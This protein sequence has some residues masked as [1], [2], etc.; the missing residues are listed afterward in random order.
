MRHRIPPTV[1]AQIET[2]REQE[3]LLILQGRLR[4][5]QDDGGKI[6]VTID[7]GKGQT[8]H[9]LTVGFLVNCTGPRESLADNPADLFRN[10]LQRG[11]V[12]PDELDMGIEVTP[13]FATVDQEG[14]PSAFLFALGPLLKGTLWE[15]TAVPN[16]RKP[17]RSRSASWPAIRC[18]AQTGRPKHRQTWWNTTSENVFEETV[19]AKPLSRARCPRLAA[20]AV[21]IVRK[22]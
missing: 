22:A 10:L 19:G 4:A 11:L 15:T 9:Q 16:P 7:P 18:N 5:A 3:K 2:A 21:A 8:P 20:F 12:R 13:D 1:A 6:Q 14:R 17:I